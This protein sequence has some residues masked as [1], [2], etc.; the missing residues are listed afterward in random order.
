MMTSLDCVEERTDLNALNKFVLDNQELESLEG[1]LQQFNIFE[2]LGAVRQELRHSDFL[3]YLLDPNQNHG[4]GD[5]FAKRLLQKSL[6]FVTGAEP[7]LSPVHLDIWSLNSAVVLR[8]WQGIDILLVDEQNRLTVVIENKIDASEHSGQLSRYYEAAQR[9]HPNHRIVPLLLTP[10]GQIPSDDRYTPIDY[11]VISS[12]LSELA[13][14][15]RT[16]IGPDVGTMLVHYTHMLR[17]HIVNDSEIPELCRQLYRKHRR[18]LDLIFEHRPDLQ[19]QVSEELQGLIQQHSGLIMDHCSKSFVRFAPVEW[20]VPPL[21]GGSGWTPS[22]AILL[23]EC[24]NAPDKLIIR[25][26]IGP[27]PDET[28]KKLFDLASKSPSVFKPS[29]K[30]LNAKWNTI[31]T[32]QVLKKSDMETKDFEQLQE[33]I[34]KFWERFLEQDLPAISKEIQTQSWH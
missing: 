14:T 32:R 25:L 12:L 15:R 23:Y 13:E 21:R 11:G 28:R 17:R 33:D 26:I 8:E 27:G 19:G 9:Q 24:L 16:V 5:A 22:G 20:D 34:K 7:G 1:R 3:A 29:T 2:A 18:A 6:T 30:S 10:E 31:W 4:L